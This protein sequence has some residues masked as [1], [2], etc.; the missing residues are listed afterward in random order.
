MTF[1]KDTNENKKEQNQAAEY[2]FYSRLLKT[3]FDTVAA[4]KEAEAAYL[5]EQ[6]KKAAKVEERKS[7]AN[8]VQA[9]FEDL[10]TARKEYKDCLI[11][12]KTQYYDGLAKL[13]KCYEEDL[14]ANQEMLEQ[15]ET[16]YSEALKVFTDKY[17]EGYHLTLKDGDFETTISG[18]TSKNFRM[19]TQTWPADLFDLFFKL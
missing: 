14:A 13:K 12:L 17:P 4:L 5:A 7:D 9:A 11:K 2:G 18:S 8:K 1:K 19:P 6:E 15:A 3:D 16:R 10:N